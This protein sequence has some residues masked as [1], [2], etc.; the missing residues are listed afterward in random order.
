VL[1]QPGQQ[2]GVR[3]CIQRVLALQ[4]GQ[5]RPQPGVLGGERSP[6]PIP[7]HGH[8]SGGQPLPLRGHGRVE[9]QQGVRDPGIQVARLAVMRLA[10]GDRR[11]RVRAYGRRLCLARPA[12][13]AAVQR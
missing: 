7:C 6:F 13:P 3:G 2:R 11:P 8:L 10:F 5:L 9:C 4:P 12:A 1:C